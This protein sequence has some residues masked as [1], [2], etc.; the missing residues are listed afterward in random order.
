M[1]ESLFLSC[2]ITYMP[3]NAV[4]ERVVRIDHDAVAVHAIYIDGQKT[5][6]HDVAGS[7]LVTSQDNERIAIDVDQGVWRSDFRGLARGLGQCTRMI[8]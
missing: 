3:T 6:K 8:K 7:A 4:W 2:V 1:I 5:Y